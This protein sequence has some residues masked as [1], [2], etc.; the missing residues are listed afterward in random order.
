[1]MNDDDE[2]YEAIK[3]FHKSLKKRY[4]NNF[5]KSEGSGFVFDYIHLLHYK[6]HK[7]NPDCGELYIDLLTG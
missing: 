4:Q 7:T 3:K 5:L 6:C 2:A 1:M